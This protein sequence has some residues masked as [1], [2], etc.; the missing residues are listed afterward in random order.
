MGLARPLKHI[1]IYA[2]YMRLAIEKA[3]EGVLQG[4]SPF[5]AVI[6]KKRKIIASV[7]NKVWKDCDIT[8]HAEITAIREACKKL[9][10]VD[11]SVCTIYTTCE[12]CPMC[13]GA[14][15]WARISMVVFGCKISDAKEIGFSELTV[16]ARRLKSLGKSHVAVVGGLL[17]EECLE[18]MELWKELGGRPY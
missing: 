15:H 3:R 13:F 14:I 9:N 10:T 7:H 8:A 16:S 12:P 4:Q 5:G 11:L 6:V 1:T 17:R 18:V 2:K